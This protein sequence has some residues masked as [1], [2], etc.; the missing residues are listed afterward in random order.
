M[1]Q[2]LVQRP[3]GEKGA[4]HFFSPIN[5]INPKVEYCLMHP[6]ISIHKGKLGFPS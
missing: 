2:S 3:L 5:L 1:G 6:W 4:S